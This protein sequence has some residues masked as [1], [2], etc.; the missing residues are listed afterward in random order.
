MTILK[1]KKLDAAQRQLRTAITLWF[2]DGDP[3]AIHALAF[4]AYEVIHTV[5]KK[6]NPYR[7]DL[8][9]D[10]LL[11]KDE[12]R[13]D[14]CIKLKEHAWFFKHADRDSEAEIEFNS[15]LSEGFIL[16]AILGRELCG[17]PQS[18]EESTYLW[19]L[20]LH[21]PS[22]LTQK[23]RDA[24]AK[25]MPVENLQYIRRLSKRDFFEGMQDA[26]R[27]TGRPFKISADIV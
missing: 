17:E 12:Y 26:R 4:A 27:L 13:K 3:V 2:H 23:G 24:L 25:L 1:L 18:Q 8:L 16:Y 19:W 6:R 5:S 15:E 7:R 22:I 20:Q 21:H 9:F 11:I 10:T 14:F